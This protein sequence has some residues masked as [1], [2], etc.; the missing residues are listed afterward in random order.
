MSPPSLRDP[1]AIL[2]LSFYEL[3]HQPH[4]LALTQAFLERAGWSPCPV[5]LAVE[6]LG[7]EAIDAA[8]LVVFVV[9]MH[10]ALRLAIAAAARI[11]GRHPAARHCFLGHYASLNEATLRRLGADFVLGGEAE[12]ELVR[13]CQR[14]ATEEPS[15]PASSPVLTRLAFPLPSRRELPAL[16]RYARAFRDGE[17]VLAGYTEASRGCRH[18]CRHCPLPPL[19][20]G[21]LFVVPVEVV[22]ADAVQ[23]QRAGARHL[24]FGDPDFLNAPRHALAIARALHRQLPELT[25]D[26]TAKVEHLLHHAALLPELFALGARFVTTAVESLSDEILAILDKGHTAADVERLVPIVA[27]SGLALR[28][29]LLPFTPWTTLDDYRALVHFV[30]RHDLHDQVD[31]VQLALRLLV[32]PGSLLADHP[33]F[34]PHRGALDEGALSYAWRHPDPRLD[35]LQAQVFAVAARAAESEEPAPRT[36]RAIHLLAAGA[37]GLDPPSLPPRPERQSPRLAEPWFC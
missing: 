13:L 1:G 6:P 30:E 29:T 35:R 31:P 19:Y 24:T 17:E 25:F 28:P 27:A 26:F 20:G 23:Q 36:H 5:D 32:P 3:G 14:L 16:G 18:L 22:V 4:G 21:R 8:R 9:P 15:P 2:L 12:E 11:R 37:A 7:D 33:A 10:T 34:T